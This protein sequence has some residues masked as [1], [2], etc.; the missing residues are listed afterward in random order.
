[1]FSA[2]LVDPEKYYESNI[3]TKSCSD[4]K[5]ELHTK[6]ELRTP[7]NKEVMVTHLF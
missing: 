6:Y 2:P 5:F 1:M 4:P 3:E 7:P